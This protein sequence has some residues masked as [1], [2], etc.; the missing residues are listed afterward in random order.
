MNLKYGR[1]FVMSEEKKKNGNVLKYF[2]NL[3]QVYTFLTAFMI[4]SMT[5]GSDIWYDEV[6][7]VEFAGFDLPKMLE[8]AIRDVHPPLYYIY[9]KAVTEILGIFGMDMIRAC[10]LASCIPLIIMLVFAY[11]W[12]RKKYDEKVMTLFAFLIVMMPQLATYYVE[13]RMYSLAMMFVT[14]SYA[15]MTDILDSEEI[16]VSQFTVLFIMSLAAAYTQYFAAVA[17]A[18]V[19]IILL[20]GILITHK[21]KDYLKAV[22]SMIVLSVLFYIPW[23]PSFFRQISEVSG[24]YWIQPMSIKSIPGCLKFMF[25]PQVPNQTAGYI[26][27]V[28]MIAICFISYILFFVKKP[29]RKEML[30]ICT[31][32][33][34]LAV[35]V[36]V[37]FV[38]STLGSPIFTYRYLIPLLGIV[39]LNIAA[40]LA[41]RK[42]TAVLYM[43]FFFCMIIGY[44]SFDGFYKEESKKVGAWQEASERLDGIETGSAIITNFDHVTAISSYYLKDSDVYLYEG[45]VDDV[46]KDIFGGCDSV[47]DEGIKELIGSKEHVYFFGSFNSREDIV[48]AWEEEGIHS[49]YTGECL[50]ERYW[51]NIYKLSS[52]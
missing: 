14:F 52:K 19:Y 31:G 43:I 13:I 16:K 48:A 50:V 4:I 17:V 36:I 6:F 41:D 49:E 27:A 20:A 37:G 29:D 10:K 26:F 45:E 34:V 39:Y 7:S 8:M 25:L 18:T 44:A 9:L 15:A 32:P 40:V 46:I 22:I 42:N 23:L 2:G 3:I 1:I 35:T 30:L 33:I 28:I 51:F 38:F 24:S 12:V 21:N 47:D 5:K 11:V